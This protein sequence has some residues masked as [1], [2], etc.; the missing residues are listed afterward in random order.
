M[1]EH[2]VFHA[3]GMVLRLM[4]DSRG[5]D[6]QGVGQAAR[7]FSRTR[8]ISSKKSKRLVALD[9]CVTL[10]RHISGV[11]VTTRM[12]DLRIELGDIVV[13]AANAFVDADAELMKEDAF[14]SPV[15]NDGSSR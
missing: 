1:A 13:P 7:L 8:A 9:V 5:H 6:F 15:T 4:C 14:V 11:S 3:H 12:H 2:L 10:L